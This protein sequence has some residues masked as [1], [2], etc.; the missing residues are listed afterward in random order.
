[1]AKYRVLSIDG[2]GIRGLITTVMMQRLAATPGLEGFLDK[3]DLIAGTSTGGL[4]A[5]GIARGLPLDEIRDLY[6]FTQ[7]IHP[8]KAI[9]GLYFEVATAPERMLDLGLRITG[10]CGTSTF[11][12][13]HPVGYWKK[14]A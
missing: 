5:L 4:L 10:R 8:D 13:R 2:G 11:E 12:T 6:F 3:V 7:S 1:M 9:V 14:S